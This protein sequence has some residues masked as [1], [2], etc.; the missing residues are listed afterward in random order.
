MY[1]LYVIQYFFRSG[2]Q[3]HPRMLL[4]ESSI[5]REPDLAANVDENV[6]ETFAVFTDRDIE[7]VDDEEEELDDKETEVDDEE[8]GVDNKEEELDDKETELNDKERGMDG[9]ERGVDGNGGDV[10]Q[11]DEDSFLSKPVRK[12]GKKSLKRLS[13]SVPVQPKKNSFARPNTIS[14]A[15]SQTLSS[16][17]QV[18]ISVAKQ[19]SYIRPTQSFPTN[20]HTQ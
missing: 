14:F 19:C 6:E 4:E 11:E 1:I 9:E 5:T 12:N 7:E 16:S 10:E 15:V 13:T 17:T 2:D 18:F 3:R 20:T 8:R